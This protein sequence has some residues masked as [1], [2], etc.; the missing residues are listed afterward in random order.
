MCLKSGEEL[1][2]PSSCSQYTFVRFKYPVHIQVQVQVQDLF[3]TYT[4][5]Q[6]VLTSSEMWV[7]DI[8]LH[9]MRF[10]PSVLNKKN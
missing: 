5:I 10:W 6:R 4:I 3:V 1:H 9:I 7:S 2:L 8:A